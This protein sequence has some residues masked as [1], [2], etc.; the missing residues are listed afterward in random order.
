MSV[1]ATV[2]N[3]SITATMARRL[4]DCG[5]DL[6]DERQVILALKESRFLSG[7]IIAHMDNAIDLA[8]VMKSGVMED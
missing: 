8:R 7:E 6:G 4:V 1:S 3:P 2:K 5:I